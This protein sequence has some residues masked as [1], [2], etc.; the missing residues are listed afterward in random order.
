MAFVTKQRMAPSVW[1]CGNAAA[2]TFLP[3]MT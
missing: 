1:G 2:P 3:A